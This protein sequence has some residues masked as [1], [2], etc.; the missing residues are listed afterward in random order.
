MSGMSEDTHQTFN[1]VI[2]IS[3]VP[4]HLSEVVDID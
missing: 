1:D 3:E 2:D 4:L